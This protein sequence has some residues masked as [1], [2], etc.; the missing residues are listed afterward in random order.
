ME[1][2]GF[3][4][5]DR[6]NFMVSD[7]RMAGKI[8]FSRIFK[9]QNLR[10]NNESENS[11]NDDIRKKNATENSIVF[12]EVLFR[13]PSLTKPD[14]SSNSNKKSVPSSLNEHNKKLSNINTCKGLQR[15]LELKVEKAK[16]HYHPGQTN[17]NE[18]FQNL[19]VI[20]VIL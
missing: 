9:F 2:S 20:D 5:E 19:E 11:S 6:L 18:R 10:N 17:S 13:N 8:R 1:D 3:D 14:E 12:E 16:R 7:E 15:K 4:S